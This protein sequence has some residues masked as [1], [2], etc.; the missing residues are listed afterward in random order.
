MSE[1]KGGEIYT[2]PVGLTVHCNECGEKLEAGDRCYI[3]DDDSS[4]IYC[5]EHAPKPKQA[6]AQRER[7]AFV[8]RR[9]LVP[10]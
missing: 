10:Q 1:I 3:E 4:S 8:P 6:A 5:L 9:K 7:A 2:V